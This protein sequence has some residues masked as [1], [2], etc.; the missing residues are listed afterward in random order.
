M[1]LVSDTELP[2]GKRPPKVA[3]PV[4]AFQGA[5]TPE[6]PRKGAPLLSGAAALPG[7]ELFSKEY[8]FEE[9][10][11]PGQL[12]YLGQ[13]VSQKFDFDSRNTRSGFLGLWCAEQNV[14]NLKKMHVQ[15]LWASCAQN[16][17]S[18]ISQKAFSEILGLLCAEQNVGTL[19]HCT[20]IIFGTPVRRTKRRKS[21]NMNF[22]KLWDSGS[23]NKTSYISNNALSEF[24][25]LRFAEQPVGSLRNARP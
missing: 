17:T 24:V 16:K 2:L 25:G 13:N 7:A 19:K 3:Y 4:P 6:P 11:C 8:V 9:I 15:E 23:Q 10:T 5:P 20:F 12:R 18:E 14:V 1:K 22:Q 21:Q